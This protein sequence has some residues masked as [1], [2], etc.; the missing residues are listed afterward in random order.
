[1]PR[2]LRPHR[3]RDLAGVLIIS[4]VTLVAVTGLTT[5]RIWQQGER[6][7]RRPVDAIVVL[8]AAQY[9][10]RPSPVFQARLDHAIELWHSGIAG[11]FVV[12]GGKLPGDRTTE[13]AVARQYA[14]DHGV[15][16]SAIYGEHAAHNTLDSLRSVA[17]LMRDHGDR[18]AVFVSDPT[19]MLR[20]LRIAQD[21]GIDGYGS[22]TTTS[23]LRGDPMRTLTATVHELGALAVYFLTGGAPPVEQPGG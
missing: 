18:T 10:G 2:S 3:I 4:G 5:V 1:V 16:P 6:D 21:L 15:P 9:N 7:E 20:V 11:A 14:I 17:A 8:G 22:P 23:P 19:H 12:T 13:A